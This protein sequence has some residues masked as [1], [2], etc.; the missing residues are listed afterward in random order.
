MYIAYLQFKKI[1]EKS[2]KRVHVNAN[3]LDL[4]VAYEV[5]FIQYEP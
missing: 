5:Q 3:M 1:K 2:L 4:S